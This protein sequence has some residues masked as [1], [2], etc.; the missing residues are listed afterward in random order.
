MLRTFLIHI[1]VET[2]KGGFVLG[3]IGS[4]VFEPPPHLF[5]ISKTQYS[6]NIT[7]TSHRV[8]KIIGGWIVKNLNFREN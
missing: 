1:S 4:L 8:E 5:R 3:G 7:Q 6:S 2:P